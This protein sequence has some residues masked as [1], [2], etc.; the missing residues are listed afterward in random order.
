MLIVAKSLQ[1]SHCAHPQDD[2]SKF[3]SRVRWKAMS[4]SA[5][6]SLTRKIAVASYKDDL[7]AAAYKKALK[8]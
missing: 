3:D 5:M 8:G 6:T 2:Q 7:A 1:V 4:G